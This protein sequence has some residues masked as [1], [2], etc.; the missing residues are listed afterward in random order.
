MFQGNATVILS[1]QQYE[2]KIQE[3]LSLPAYKKLDKDPTDSIKRKLDVI[4]KK[5]VKEKKISKS[6]HDS[7][8]VLH[9]R[10]PHI[11][12]LP[13]IHIEGTPIRPIVAFC[14]SPLS[15]L[16]K[17][18]SELL[19]LLTL[20]PLRLKDSAQFKDKFQSLYDPDYSY[21]ASLDIKSLYTSCDMKLATSLALEQLAQRPNILPN[22]ITIEGI[23]SLLNFSLDHC[24]FHYNNIFFQQVEGGPMGS[25]LTVTLAEIRVTH[26]ELNA[27]STS[28]HPP[29]HYFH[30]VDDGF[31][32]FKNESHARTFLTHINSLTPDLQYTLELP[33]HNRSLPYLDILIHSDNST[34]I[35]RKPTHT[36]VYTHYN[37][38][39]P[40][41]HKDS[42]IRS[43][44]RRAY[45]LCS[46]QHLQPELE[47]LKNTFLGN[48][49]PLSYILLIMNQT[50]RSIGK[51]KTPSPNKQPNSSL[52][53]VLPYNQHFAKDL[54]KTLARYDIETS[55]RTAPTLKNLLCNT[56]SKSDPKRTPNCIYK[57]SCSNCPD[58]YIGQTYR[59]ISLRIKEHEASYRLNNIYDSATGNIKSAPAKH[60]CDNKHLINF[61]SVEILTTTS[62]RQCLNL[63][64]HAAIVTLDPPLNR[65]HAGPRINPCWQALLPVITRSFNKSFSINNLVT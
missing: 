30:F 19:K 8:R 10:P 45:T 49:Y 59:P 35:Y 36:N 25:P 27:L 2:D 5:L 9:P 40:Q 20:S 33:N 57:L 37:S 46:P 12:G 24:Y 51:S 47:F 32:F 16:H 3:H 34:S 39:S 22:G 29:K 13:K 55:F 42:I 21:Y 61:N 58:F 11:Y 43:L 62:N 1:K 54:K 28:P 31:G 17:Q 50:R 7:A 44:T 18:L 14:N 52:R 15:A 53:V 4:L 64:E 23:K 60:A 6:F 38:C 65:Q 63:L 41:V 26:N 48:G 56:S